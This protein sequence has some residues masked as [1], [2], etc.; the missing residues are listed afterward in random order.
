L[1]AGL[2]SEAEQYCM[3]ILAID[4]P[5]EVN[6]QAT[7]ILG[8]IYLHRDH[9]SAGEVFADMVKYCQTLLIETGNLY[10]VRYKLAASMVGQAV[11][12]PCWTDLNQRA[13]L[14]LP[15]ISEYRRALAITTAPGVVRDA[16]RD[17]EFICAAGIEGLEPI[18]ALLEGVL[19]DG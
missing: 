8:I 19:V 18:F 5:E 4:V 9:V 10:E 11:C 14:L 3:E 15:A 13:D 2:L 17:L 1:S 6:Y 7:L 16:L 12:D